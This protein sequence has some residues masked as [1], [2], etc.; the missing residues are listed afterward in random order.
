MKKST[1]FI[2]ASL[3]LLNGM[4]VNAAEVAEISEARFCNFQGR[5]IALRI[6]EEVSNDLSTNERSQIAEIAEEVCENYYAEIALIQT[7]E[8]AQSAGSIAAQAQPDSTDNSQNIG[9]QGPLI[10]PFEDEEGLLGDLR[11]IDSEDRVRRPGLKR[12]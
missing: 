3:F 11:I 9:Q 7:S 6:S 12:R 5:E 8:S 4:S 10:A 1:L 2:I